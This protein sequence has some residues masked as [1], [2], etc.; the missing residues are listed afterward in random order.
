MSNNR[1]TN[2]EVWF[3]RDEDANAYGDFFRG[4]VANF[5]IAGEFFAAMVPDTLTANAVRT[6]SGATIDKTTPYTLD[7]V[8][9]GL[10]VLFIIIYIQLK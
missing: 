8:L 9:I 10:I 4:Q 1:C 5:P 2:S 6:C 7:V 3:T